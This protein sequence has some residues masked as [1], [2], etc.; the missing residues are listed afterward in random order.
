MKEKIFDIVEKKEKRLVVKTWTCLCLLSSQAREKK[1][2]TFSKKVQPNDAL[3]RKKKY[4]WL[5]TK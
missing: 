3:K 1:K 5:R 2:Q 4:F